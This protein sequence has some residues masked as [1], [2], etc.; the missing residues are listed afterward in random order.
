MN[1]QTATT[2]ST[3]ITT[4]ALV[5]PA[6]G[7]RNRGTVLCLIVHDELELRLRLAGLVRRAMPKIDADTVTRAGFDAISIERLRAYVAVMFIVEFSPPEAAAGSLASLKRL[8]EQA[9][10]LPIFVFARGG[11]ER[12]AAR[13]MKLGASDYWPIH[14][15]IVGELCSALQPL[16]EPPAAASAASSAAADRWKQPEIAG[17]TMMKKIAQS[18]AASVYLARNDEFPQPVALKVEAIKGQH[19][20]SVADRERFTKECEILSK[21]NHR[22]IANV[23]DY[24]TTDDY[25]YLALEYFPCGSLRER[26]KHPVSEADA[27]NYA[28]QI[29]EAL[30]IV[31]AARV[32]HRDLKPSNLMLTN[33]NRLVLIDFGS[34]RTQFMPS[35]LARSGDC[36][37]TP[38]YV[39]PEQIDDREPDA[40]GDLYSL[41]VVF[42]EM[43]AGSLPFSGKSLAE[44]LAAHRSAAVP[45]LPE[46]LAAYQ[47]I[48]DR[49]LAKDPKDRYA[50]AAEFLDALDALRTEL[51]S[52]KPSKLQ[53]SV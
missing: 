10:G 41:G 11:N 30:Q 31:H 27:V 4:T 19:V 38:Y 49:L 53:R 32:V 44:I 39:C 16:L 1:S 36:T 20:V 12:S 7:E 15:V 21:L 46:T 22:S 3:T 26:L 35:D 17:Y 9:P 34:A 28:H 8:H 5:P 37:G 52:R 47:P 13:A 45:R 50:S 2:T 18:T 51:L 24:G 42:Y 14:S 48:I 33:E 40:R 23:L 25:L 29:G 6:A 43:L